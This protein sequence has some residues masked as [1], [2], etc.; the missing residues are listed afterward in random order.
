MTDNYEETK[1]KIRA[2]VKIGIVVYLTIIFL[3]F[4]EGSLFDYTNALMERVGFYPNQVPVLGEIFCALVVIQ[5]FG[6]IFTLSCALC[7]W[8]YYVGLRRNEAV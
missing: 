6:I 4:I 3:W 5:F 7:A 1:L 8:I 2:F